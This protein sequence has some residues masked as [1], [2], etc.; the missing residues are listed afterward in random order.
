MSKIPSSPRIAL[1]YYQKRVEKRNE[2]REKE[3]KKKKKKK[4]R[5]LAAFQFPFRVVIVRAHWPK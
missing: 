1:Q 3:Q 4:K 5:K 2:N